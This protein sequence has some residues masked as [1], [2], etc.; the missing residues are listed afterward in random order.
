VS[1]RLGGAPARGYDRQ[2]VNTGE[3]SL[4]ARGVA[5]ARS[6]LTR[7]QTPEGDPGAELRLYA[8]LLAPWRTDGDGGVALGR[9]GSASNPG[10]RQR[11]FNIVERTAFIDDETLRAVTAGIDQVVLVGAGYDGRALRFRRSGVRFF[12]L[13]HPATQADKRR[14]LEALGAPLDDVTFVEVDLMSDRVD[15]ALARAG[16]CGDRPS[17]FVC[18]GLVRYLSRV[19]V[20]RMLAGLRARAVRGSRL[21]ITVAESA[22]V[23]R[24]LGRRFY[25]AAIGEP[26]R[27]SYALGEFRRRLTRSGWVVEREARRAEHAGR[28]RLLIAA[29]P[30]V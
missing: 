12:E 6:R 15:A 21:L 14:R 28:D 13:D 20:D 18:E 4:T 10:R 2:P 5:L 24:R 19:A 27:S 7:P 29:T 25:L 9:H 30:G 23:D 3:P 17:L 26:V 8:G 11:R 22:G 1:S 16:H